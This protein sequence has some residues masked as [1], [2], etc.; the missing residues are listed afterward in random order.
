MPPCFSGGSSR[1]AFLFFFTEKINELLVK[2]TGVTYP[3]RIRFF[4]VKIEGTD[5]KPP[6]ENN[7]KPLLK[8]MINFYYDNKYKIHPFVLACLIHAMLVEVHPFEDGTGRT[9]RSLLNWVLAKAKY[10][11]LYI[12]VKNRESYY[13]AIDQHNIK[14]YKGYCESMFDLVVSQMKK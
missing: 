13:S 11:T 5:F 10:P 3:G 9:G 8:K 6:E 4:P 12:P 14:N 1:F 7:V 2:N